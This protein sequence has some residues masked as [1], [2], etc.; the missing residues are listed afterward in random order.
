MVLLIIIALFCL[1][2][3]EYLRFW[4][5]N[6]DY[7]NKVVDESKTG[8]YI[9]VVLTNLSRKDKNFIYL[10]GIMFLIKYLQNNNIP[11]KL[12]QKFDKEQFEEFI[13]DTNCKGLYIIGHGVRHGLVVG[14]N[15]MLYYGSFK[16]APKNKKFVVQLHC[17]THAGESL[18]DIIAPN[19]PQSFVPDGCRYTN[20]NLSYFLNLYKPSLKKKVVLLP[21]RIILHVLNFIVKTVFK[22]LHI[23]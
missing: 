12:I 22:I 19:M 6:A 7:V 2:L 17:N 14:K 1:I 11:Y 8:E 20:E 13:Y 9:G 15:E 10:S 23:C 21:I 4:K 3:M 16:D 5:V 18:A